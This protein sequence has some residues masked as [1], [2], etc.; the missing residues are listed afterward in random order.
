MPLS[1]YVP[2][3]RDNIEGNRL[4]EKPTYIKAVLDSR[5]FQRLRNIR[6]TGLA[7]Y[8]FPTSEHSRFVHSLGVLGTAQLAYKHI[9]ATGADH[10]LPM[11]GLRF[12]D[13]TEKDFCI[14]TMCHDLGH[15]AFSH[16]LETTLLPSDF[17]NHEECTLHI[18]R[19]GTQIS[20]AINDVADL[21]A[22][23]AFIQSKHP[24]PAL[25]DLV[26][27]AFDVD[28]CDYVLRDSV[29]CGVEYGQFDLKW[30]IRAISIELNKLG[31]PTLVLDGTRGM[32]A[33]RQFLSA[34]RYM[35]RQVYFHKSVRS[36]QLL[37]KSILERIQDL[38]DDRSLRSLIPKPLRCL[39]KSV[40][41]SFGDF[42]QTT[43]SEI[44]SMVQAIAHSNH[45][46]K[47]IRYLSESLIE[48]RIPK[49][50]LDS[51]MMTKPFSTA[52]RIVD[53][54]AETSSPQEEMWPL[55][56]D[57]SSAVLDDLR[58]YVKKQL[59]SSGLPVELSRYLVKFD[60]VRFRSSVPSD[61]RFKFGKVVVPFDAIHTDV[62]GF[63]LRSLLE[64]FDI[65]RLFVPK[66]VAGEASDY[67]DEHY[68]I[69]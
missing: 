21:D 55:L 10:D 36:S 24:N 53:D 58:E 22:V 17:R 8:V 43:D 35:H 62:V 46:D 60:F 33:L 16:L 11:P 12:D 39:Q 14:A 47:V 69:Q 48:R 2:V 19:S 9:R 28:R 54:N 31:Q 30:L 59:K 38:E 34:R 6:Q 68:R 45:K 52:Y 61:F 51:A 41:P 7:S 3:L 4:V 56:L 20:N 42:L 32:D 1:A 27:G 57:K 25:N 26:S 63:D 15:T 67:V 18:L 23:C 65:S 40:R 29:M 50:I 49:C 5:E 37:L 13:D 66:E 44:L 64:T